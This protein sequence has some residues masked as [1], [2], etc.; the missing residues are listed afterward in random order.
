ML[1]MTAAGL[2]SRGYGVVNMFRTNIGG[3]ISS[4]AFPAFAREHHATGTA[5]ALFLKSRVYLT[6]ISW[7]FF[8]AGAL[9]AFP[10][11]RVLF[12][13]QWDAAVPLMRWLCFAALVD[14]L[15]YQCDAFLVAIGRVRAAT[16]IAV[17]Y[18]VGRIVLTV[19]AAFYSLEAVAAVQ[20]LVY[21]I[22]VALYYADLNRHAGLSL[23]ALATGLVP[24]IVVA[25]A[26]CVVPS[27]VVFWPGLLQRH[28]PSSFCVAIVGGSISWL[29]AVMWVRHPLLD[30]IKRAAARFMPSA[31]RFVGRLE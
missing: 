10:I 23:R 26:T 19:A 9:L 5:A 17:Q 3:A 22:A 8:G 18:Q 21:A 15:I 12:G 13:T 11:I 29:L 25:A 28:M 14:T 1:G 20:V 2:Y 6:G 4:V 7:P 27:V 16:R 31:L 30:E 24:S